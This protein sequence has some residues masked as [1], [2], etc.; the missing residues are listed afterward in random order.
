M[1]QNIKRIFERQGFIRLKGVLDYKEDLEPILNLK[2]LTLLDLE[3]NESKE[4]KINFYKN[5]GL[6][7]HRLKDLDYFND[8]LGVSSIIN[9]CDVIITCSNV[10]AH[11]S[12][13][14]GKKTFLLLP[15]GKGR[16]L[17]WSS[18]KNYSLW[19]PSIKIFQQTAPGQRRQL[20]APL[21][22]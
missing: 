15:I 16:L 2:N 22:A 13:A 5:K 18:K 6:K 14:L 12:G 21:P 19:Y 9:S 11:I 7:I 20:P 17:N 3:Y 4:D 1:S 8:I 10:N